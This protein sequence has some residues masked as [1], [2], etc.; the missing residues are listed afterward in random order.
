LSKTWLI[1][2]NYKVVK[3]AEDKIIETIKYI[4][5]SLWFLPKKITIY[6]DRPMY[7]IENK[8]LL[9]EILWIPINIMFV[10]MI[11]N[12]NEPKITKID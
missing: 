6:E 3:L 8:Q 1:D 10:E 9:E 11:D 2:H 12:I 5:E 7:F 4:I